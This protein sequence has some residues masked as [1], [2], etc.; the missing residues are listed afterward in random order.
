[1][2]T[3]F[4]SVV[5]VKGEQLVPSAVAQ[6]IIVKF[7]L[8]KNVKFAEILKRLR[9]QFYDE[10]P[11][12]TEAYDWGKSLKEGGTEVKNMPRQHLLQGK[13]W[14]AFFGTLKTSCSS[15]FL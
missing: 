10:T 2:C 12:R 3:S 15:I 6:R 7:L 4:L 9:A 8:N 13:L 1:M 14:P 11:S 5:I